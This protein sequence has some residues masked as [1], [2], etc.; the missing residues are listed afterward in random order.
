MRSRRR[1][2]PNP[3]M[4]PTMEASVT[5]VNGQDLQVGVICADRDCNR[6]RI[7]HVDRDAGTLSY[8]FLNDELRVQ[9]GVQQRSIQ[10]FLAEGW[11]M[12]S[13]GKSL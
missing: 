5:K 11:Y 7:D 2:G 8:H 10:Q 4:S 1:C 6:I 9:E 12:A 13:P 3:N